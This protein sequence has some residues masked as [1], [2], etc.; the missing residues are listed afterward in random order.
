LRDAVGIQILARRNA[1]DR[2][3]SCFGNGGHLS[4]L[5]TWREL[6][7]LRLPKILSGDAV[8]W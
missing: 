6:R 1:R 7:C 2:L 4:F 5:L 3:G 8:A